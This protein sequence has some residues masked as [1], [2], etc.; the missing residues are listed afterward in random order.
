MYRKKYLFY[1]AGMPCK[2]L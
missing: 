1:L 2:I